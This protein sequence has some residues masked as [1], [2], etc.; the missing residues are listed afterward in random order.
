MSAVSDSLEPHRLCQYLFELA[1][2]FSVFF[3]QCPVLAAEPPEL[4]AARLR[5]TAL[6]GRV[7]EDGLHVLGIPTLERM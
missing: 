3:D 6:T 5:L 2:A 1:G 4:R 7:L